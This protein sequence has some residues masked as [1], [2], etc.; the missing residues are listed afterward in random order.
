MK[1]QRWGYSKSWN[2]VIFL[3]CLFLFS[4]FFTAVML[5]VC[6]Q[7]FSARI[8]DFITQCCSQ[9]V[10]RFNQRPN[11][12]VA[13]NHKYILKSIWISHRR[14]LSAETTEPSVLHLVWKKAVGAMDELNMTID[15]RGTSEPLLFFYIKCYISWIMY[16]NDINLL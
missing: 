7:P 11:C 8:S 9:G 13:T 6:S 14:N 5:L 3:F 16:C 2:S 12:T 10:N 4:F 15:H 1:K